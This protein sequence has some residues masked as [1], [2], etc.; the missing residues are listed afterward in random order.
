LQ[1]LRAAE[2]NKSFFLAEKDL[3]CI[4]HSTDPFYKKDPEDYTNYKENTTKVP[5]L[6]RRSPPPTTPLSQAREAMTLG[7]RPPAKTKAQLHALESP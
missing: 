1:A 3:Y 2:D 6:H 7:R 4:K 5:N